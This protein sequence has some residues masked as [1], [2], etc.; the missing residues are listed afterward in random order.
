MHLMLRDPFC[1]NL[2]CV[3]LH[4]A[5][6]WL[7]AQLSWLDRWQARQLEQVPVADATISP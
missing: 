3:E 2:M 1:D 5:E 6:H 4:L 7:A